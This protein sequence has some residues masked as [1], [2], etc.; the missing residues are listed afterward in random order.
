MR[1]ARHGR[2]ERYTTIASGIG[3]AVAL[4]SVLDPFRAIASYLGPAIAI[5]AALAG[6]RRSL[7]V[8]AIVATCYGLASPL[9]IEFRAD[10]SSYFA[11]LRSMSFDGDLDFKNDW[12]L[13]RD[14]EPSP[15]PT[16]R[17]IN[18]FSAGPAV[19]WSPFFWA[20]HA[21][22][23]L[24]GWVGRALYEA[25]GASLP[26]RRATLAGTIAVVVVGASL[27]ASTLARLHGLTI[28]LLAT[29]GAVLGSPVA[30]YTFLVPAMPHGVTFGVACAYLWAWDS[31]RRSPSR[32]GWVLVGGL[33]G[34]LT[35]CRWQAALFAL[36]LVPLAVTGLRRKTLPPSWLAGCGIAAAV[37]FLPQ[38]FAWRIGFGEWILIPQ[39]RGFLDFSSAHW[40]D[41][42]ISADHGFFNWTP[43]MLAGFLGMWT[44]LRK[45]FTFY[46]TS[47]GVF[48][49]TAWVN[50]S[51]PDFDWAGGDA[52][53][54]RRYCLVVPLLAFGL[55]RAVELAKSASVRWPLLVPTVA[56]AAFVVWNLGLISHFRAR[57][58]PGAAPFERLARDQARSLR[59]N[60]EAVAGAI[61]GAEGRALAYKYFSAEYF[62]TDF[63]TSGTI[64]LRAADERYLLEGWHTPS[65][66]IARR[67]FRRALYPRACVRI[68]LESPFPLRV[69]TT[70]RAAEGVQP[71]TVT[72][73]VNETRLTTASLTTQWRD[74]EVEIPVS[75]LVPGENAFCLTF[76]NA[77][78]EDAA[79]RRVAALVERIQL[80]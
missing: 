35:M 12:D 24:D 67:T 20:A 13:L 7:S 37:A 42:L 51:V 73:V 49:A 31:V 74:V 4:V 65:R 61:A 70:A 34:L 5:A 40:L 23:K 32:G 71:Q 77:Q 76:S 19:L 30:Y 72:F 50:G 2:L 75:A 54:A 27:L 44:G 36:F 59:K 56:M 46:A 29:L 60:I 26:Y 9:L 17:E 80:P 58:Y 16:R 63:N 14:G 28:A 6:R 15:F 25:D 64:L 1:L 69:T 22:V 62:Y 55:A 33:L 48:F 45:D 52:F 41:T 47:L 21:Y 39:G 18:V 38:S 68:P 53:G 66:R 10:S 8:V 78:P 43:L 11:Y 3:V 57:K 79:G